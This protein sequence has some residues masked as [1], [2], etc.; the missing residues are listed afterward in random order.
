MDRLE[1][2]RKHRI[3]NGLS[4]FKAPVEKFV[5][6]SDYDKKKM[7]KEMEKEEKETVEDKAFIKMCEDNKPII[8][9]IL[10][11]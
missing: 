6:M 11:G 8:H 7:E 9:D 3:E 4:T 2:D 10:K 1:A 5:R